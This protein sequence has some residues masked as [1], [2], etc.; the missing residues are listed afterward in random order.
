MRE[1]GRDEGHKRR[2]TVA[3]PESSP[4]P[5]TVNIHV[6]AVGEPLGLRSVTEAGI[7]QLDKVPNRW[8]SSALLN[9]PVIARSICLHRCKSRT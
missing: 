3:R 9:D 2:V 4:A 6:L 8:P 7:R 5:V 1:A